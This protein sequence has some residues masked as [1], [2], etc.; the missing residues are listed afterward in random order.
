MRCDH[1]CLSYLHTNNSKQ[2]R[3][4]TDKILTPIVKCRAILK[5]F[6]YI[7]HNVKPIR[8]IQDIIQLSLCHKPYISATV[9][10]LSCLGIETVQ[11]PCSQCFDGPVASSGRYKWKDL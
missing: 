9:C 8:T 7:I 10:F 6:Q 5:Y 2:I 11:K 1:E 4:R 3:D